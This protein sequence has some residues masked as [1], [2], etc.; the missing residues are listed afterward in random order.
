VLS[1]LQHVMLWSERRLGVFASHVLPISHRDTNSTP[2]ININTIIRQLHHRHHAPHAR[3]FASIIIVATRLPCINSTQQIHA[4]IP[5]LRTAARAR[6]AFCHTHTGINTSPLATS[7]GSRR[8][9][10]QT[11]NRPV[12]SRVGLRCSR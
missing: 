8:S 12:R 3:I 7:D 4:P 10:L 9:A 1:L 11:L 5:A 2:N 6:Q